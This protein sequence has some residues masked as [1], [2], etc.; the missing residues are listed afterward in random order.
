MHGGRAAQVRGAFE[1]ETV[2][3]IEQTMFHDQ[4]HIFREENELL[5]T[6]SPQ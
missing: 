6:N 3:N 2:M 1:E 4:T 5:D